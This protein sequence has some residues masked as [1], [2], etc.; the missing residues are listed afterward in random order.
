MKIL[1]CIKQVPDMESRFRPNG[2]KTWYDESDL[3][4][5]MNEY[6]EYAVEQAVQLKEQL[7]GEPEIT[8]LSIGPERTVEAI[9][10]ALAMGGDRAVHIRDDRYYQKDPWQ[11]ASMIASYAKG[12]GFDLIFT[13]DRKSV[14]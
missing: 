8:V 7:G 1:V 4:F 9:K 14:V 10:K 12:E 2:D 11:I 6:D 5:R 3:A 13:G